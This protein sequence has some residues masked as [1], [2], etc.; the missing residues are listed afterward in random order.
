MQRSKLSRLPGAKC[1]AAA[2]SHASRPVPNPPHQPTCRPVLLPAAPSD[3][4]PAGVELET[5]DLRGNPGL[6]P[7]VEAALEA[8]PLLARAEFVN[9]LRLL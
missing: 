8:S 1:V 2:G 4:L 3:V 9:G 6:T 5:L 7:A